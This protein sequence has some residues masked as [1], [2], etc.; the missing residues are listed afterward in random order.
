MNKLRRIRSPWHRL[1]L[2]LLISCLLLLNLFIPKRARVH[3]VGGPRKS[4]HLERLL[5]TILFPCAVIIL[6]TQEFIVWAT[7]IGGVASIYLTLYGLWRLI[8]RKRA[9]W[10]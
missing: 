7:V 9:H 4:H 5:I 2:S 3:W 1:F 10:I 6:R 8:P